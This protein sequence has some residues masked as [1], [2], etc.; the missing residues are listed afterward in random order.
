MKVRLIKADV[1][2]I[3]LWFH[4]SCRR[5]PNYLLLR[6]TLCWS[7]HDRMLFVWDLATYQVCQDEQ[8]EDS[9][10]LVLQQMQKPRPSQRQYKAQQQKEEKRNEANAERRRQ[11]NLTNATFLVHFVMIRLTGPSKIFLP[12]VCPSSQ[13]WSIP[14]RLDLST[15]ALSFTKSAPQTLFAFSTLRVC[16]LFDQ[17]WRLFCGLLHT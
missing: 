14:K 9:K 11:E 15:T 7:T 4:V 16:D 12:F 8:K 5:Q 13:I 2:F 17:H 6:Q 1:V 3:C 10:T